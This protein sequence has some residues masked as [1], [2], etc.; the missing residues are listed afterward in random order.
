MS[1]KIPMSHL[2]SAI[3]RGEVTPLITIR[4][5]GAPLNDHLGGAAWQPTLVSGSND[6]LEA[7]MCSAVVF[8]VLSCFGMR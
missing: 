1:E 2:F 4:S 7:Q 8:F 6:M 5:G 3:Y